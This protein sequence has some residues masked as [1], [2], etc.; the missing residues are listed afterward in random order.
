MVLYDMLGQ[1]LVMVDN[2]KIITNAVSG[3]A[4]TMH[5]LI[6]RVLRA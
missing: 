2:T 6:A 4:M 3:A 1:I 5:V